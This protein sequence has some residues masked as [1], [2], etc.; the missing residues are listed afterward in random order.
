MK[1]TFL[2]GIFVI[3]F[4]ALSFAQQ[5]KTF[6]II[7]ETNQNDEAMLMAL[8]MKITASVR[9]DGGE[10]AKNAEGKIGEIKP[11]TEGSKITVSFEVSSK[12]AY[13]DQKFCEKVRKAAEARIKDYVVK[14]YCGN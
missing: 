12:K 3:L 14:S 9:T 5:K 6:T 8:Q 2:F 11:K 13:N 1:K 10:A 4:S 7:F